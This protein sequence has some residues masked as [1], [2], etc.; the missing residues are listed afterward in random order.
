MFF[1]LGWLRGGGG[2]GALGAI[3]GH[4]VTQTNPKMRTVSPF[5]LSP[6]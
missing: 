1:W 6:Q 3:Q 4:P 2:G 5:C